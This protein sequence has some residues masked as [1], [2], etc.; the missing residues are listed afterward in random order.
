MVILGANYPELRRLAVK[1]VDGAFQS[2]CPD[3]EVRRAFTSRAIIRKLAEIDGITVDDERRALKRLEEDGF[4]EII[5][6]PFHIEEGEEYE[7]VMD[8]VRDFDT[9]KAFGE[10]VSAPCLTVWAK[11]INSIIN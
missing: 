6:Q 2:E 10:I 9:R 1:S 8:A 7:R 5:V 3:Y 11:P 4:S